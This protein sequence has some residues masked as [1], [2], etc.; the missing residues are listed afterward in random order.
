MTC[1]ELVATS[2]PSASRRRFTIRRAAGLAAATVCAV[3][4]F[5]G[6]VSQDQ[7]TVQTQINTER[8]AN[9]RAALVDYGAADTKAQNWANHLASLSCS[10]S[11]CLSH[12]NL[13]AGYTAGTWCHLGENVGMGP[14]LASINMGFLNSPPHRANILGSEYDHFGTGVAK[15]ESSGY[16]FV[17]QEFVDLC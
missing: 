17:V 5:A 12:T 15:N 2:P 3:A 4:V 8:Q 1:E 9:G 14:D 16:V 6:C 13:A 10:G 11:A 7:T